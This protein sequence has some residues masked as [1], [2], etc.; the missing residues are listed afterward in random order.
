MAEDVSDP[1]SSQ[2]HLPTFTF[3]LRLLRTALDT[4]PFWGSGYWAEIEA[5]ALS[6]EKGIQ[7]LLQQYRVLEDF[8]AYNST[9]VVRRTVSADNGRMPLLNRS[10]TTDVC[11]L[12]VGGRQLMLV[13]EEQGWM[14]SI[15]LSCLNILLA[16]AACE[17]RNG[18]LI[19]GS[20]APARARSLTC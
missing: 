14:R 15:I 13:T 16:E 17:R 9:E 12:P 18:S 3:W 19:R 8:V 11:H 10:K 6:L 1:E 7:D 20:V 2:P 4:D 5:R